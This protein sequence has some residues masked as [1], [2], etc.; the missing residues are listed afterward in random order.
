[1]WLT[2]NGGTEKLRFPVL[3][4]RINIRKSGANKSI[5][6]QGLGEVTIK[7]EPKA[8]M[9]SFSSFFPSTPFP[10]VQ[11]ENLTP[12]SDLKDKITIWQKSD[13]PVQFL[14][15]G[16][17]INIFCTIE[18]FPYYEQGGDIGT[19][20]YTL[21]LKEYKRVH[22]RQVKIDIPTQTAV[23]P[24]PTPARTDNRAPEKSYTV[25]KGDSL[26]V[27]AKR[28]LGNASRYIEIY[29]LNK[30]KIKNPNLIY[31]GQVLKL[32]I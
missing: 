28:L 3:P 12:P 10:G 17:T 4:E 23:V 32:P 14:V 5:S 7:Q 19:L 18:D 13:M 29:N 15:T 21:T 25:V 26:S 2:H 1:M 24:P 11:F 27:I 16:T 9:I 22:A 6:I 30:D 8:V 31:S 20:Y